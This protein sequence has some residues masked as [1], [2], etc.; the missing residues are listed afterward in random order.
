MT[1]LA[2]KAPV[3]AGPPCGLRHLA[4]AGCYDRIAERY[5]QGGCLAFA[6][7]LWIAHGCR[8]DASIAILSNDFGEG[9]GD[10]DHEATHAYLDL[11]E[12]TM[13]VRGFRDVSQ[14]AGELDIDHWSIAAEMEPDDAISAYAGGFSTD[15][16]EGDCPIDLNQDDILDA[17]VHIANHPKRYGLG[18]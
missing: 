11:P 17:L 5:L 2:L 1:A 18:E 12:G 7:A 8:R 16:E 6:Y 13:D 9:W 10:I 4:S 15:V 3:E 14:M